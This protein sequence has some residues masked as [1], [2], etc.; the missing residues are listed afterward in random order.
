MIAVKI[1]VFVV[2]IACVL[3]LEYGSSRYTKGTQQGTQDSAMGFV[4]LWVKDKHTINLPVLVG[5]GVIM[6]GGAFLFFKNKKN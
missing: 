2:I 1:A 5:V 4:D 3:G 6:V